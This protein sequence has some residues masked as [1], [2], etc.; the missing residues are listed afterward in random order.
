MA[1]LAVLV[2]GSGGRE[3]ALVWAL[4]GSPSVGAV[5]AIPGNPGIAALPVRTADIPLTDTERIVAWAVAERIDLVVVGP[6][7]PLAAGLADRLR[8]AGIAVFGP[9]RAAAEME[10][11]KAFAKAFLR[12]HGIPT[13]GYAI[14]DD[15]ESALDHVRETAFPLVVKADGLAAGK[16]VTVCATLVEAE[17]AIAAAMVDDAF[18]GAGRRLV[19][20][21]FLHGEE[22]SVIALVDGDRIAVLPPAR[23]Y[24]RLGDGDIGPNTGG[25]GS[26]APTPAVDPLLLREI[27]ATIIEPTVAGMRR[28]GRTYQ[29]ALY[30][31]L[32]LTASGPKVIEFNCRFGDPETQVILPLLEAD[33]G[34]VLHECA[35]GSLDTNQVRVRPSAAVCITLAAAGYPERPRAGATIEG[36]ADAEATGALVFHAG[37]AQRGREIVVAGG[38][39]LSVVGRGDTLDQATARAYAAADRISFEGRQLRRDIGTLRLASR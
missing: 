6:E 25:M 5:S 10:W 24:K 37:T 3:H 36:I 39:V 17:R 29:G 16:G 2:V 34:R 14:F 18:A 13:A 31:G 1:E 20:E 12:D 28:I 21:E 11:S 38:R 7:A 22:A 19:I 33:L 30:V 26:F 15:T 27:V 4:L 9:S 23:D 32:M 8:Q 35:I